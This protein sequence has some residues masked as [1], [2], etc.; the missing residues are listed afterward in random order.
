MTEFNI[1]LDIEQGVPTTDH[2][3]FTAAA[4]RWEQAV[5]NDLE[6]VESSV[7]LDTFP[8][9]GLPYEGCVYPEI[10][11]DLYICGRYAPIDGRG[12]V[13]A[14]AGP[15]FW[16]LPSFLPITGRITIDS[17]DMASLTTGDELSNVVLHEMG[18][19]LGKGYAGGFRRSHCFTSCLLTHNRLLKLRCH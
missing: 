12:L 10:I 18:H 7:I 6:D 3:V 15:T 19:V 1:C 13:L 17:A 11:D 2:Y 4:A 8:D 9:T 16:R 14:S 5:V